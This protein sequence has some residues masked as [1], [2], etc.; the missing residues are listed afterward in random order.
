MDAISKRIVSIDSVN[1]IKLHN[2]GSEGHNTQIKEKGLKAI[3]GVKLNICW[4]GRDC[5]QIGDRM[6][7]N[8][9]KLP[10]LH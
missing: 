6:S 2:L 3:Y 1:F 5:G 4:N 7:D 9:E 10:C 8:D